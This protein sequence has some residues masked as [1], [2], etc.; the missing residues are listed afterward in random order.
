ME[1]KQKQKWHML[2]VGKRVDYILLG[3][4]SGNVAYYLY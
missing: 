1:N 4:A 3:A 2:Q